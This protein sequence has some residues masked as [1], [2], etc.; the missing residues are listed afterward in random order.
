MNTANNTKPSRASQRRFNNKVRELRS[1]LSESEAK[2][3]IAWAKQV[4]G[5]LS[6]IRH[7]AWEWR[8]GINNTSEASE[9]DFVRTKHSLIFGV[10]D[11]ADRLLADCGKQAELLVGAET[12]EV[13]RAECSKAVANICDKRLYSVVQF[14]R[15]KR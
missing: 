6:E 2:F 4:D 15:V 10:V 13:L 1:L 12:R 14:S 11:L 5:W 3:K 9:K 7:R 8:K